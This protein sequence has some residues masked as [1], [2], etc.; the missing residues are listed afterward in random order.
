[1]KL[2][3]NDVVPNLGCDYVAEGDTAAEV[4]TNMTTHGGE[5]HADLMAGKSPEEMQQAKTEMDAHIS[6]LITAKN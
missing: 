1:M 2:A 5:R 6:Q 3:C 4:Q